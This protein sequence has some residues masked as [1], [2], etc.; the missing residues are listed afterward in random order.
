[1]VDKACD[2]KICI[3]SDEC[4]RFQAWLDGDK[5]FKTHNGSETKACGKFIQ[6]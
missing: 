5:N 4:A 1:M 2:N 6:K 3:K